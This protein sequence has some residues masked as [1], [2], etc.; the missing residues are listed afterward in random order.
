ME[1]RKSHYDLTTVRSL[2]KAG[3]FSTTHVA[4][5]GANMLG[6]DLADML[7]TVMQL[8]QSDFYKSMTS[9][10][11]HTVWQDVY[12]PNTSAG[13]VYIKLSIVNNLLIVSFKE[14]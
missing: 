14:L 3:K 7:A 11:D 8:T 1:K 10:K 13:S 2:I 5:S 4:R 12:R 9:H 6:F